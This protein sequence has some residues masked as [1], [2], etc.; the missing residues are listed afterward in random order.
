MVRALVIDL[1][2]ETLHGHA[3]LA[4]LV[5]LVLALAFGLHL[6]KVVLEALVFELLLSVRGNTVRALLIRSMLAL[7][8]DIL[9]GFLSHS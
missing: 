9:N 1:V 2:A 3:V 7:M 4:L 6:G 8:L 5:W